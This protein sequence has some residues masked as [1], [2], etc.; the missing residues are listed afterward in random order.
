MCA[1]CV[2]RSAQCED[3]YGQWTVTR[4]P[5]ALRG[6]LLHKPFNVRYASMRVLAYQLLQATRRMSDMTAHTHA[7]TLTAYSCNVQCPGNGNG[8]IKLNASGKYATTI[9]RNQ[10]KS[11]SHNNNNNNDA[12]A[13]K[14]KRINLCTP[15]LRLDIVNISSLKILK[16]PMYVKFVL[17]SVLLKIIFIEYMQQHAT[18]CS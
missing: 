15:L 3:I 12:A 9:T 11:Y 4:P 16:I 17:G 8:K 5:F 10:N 18:C 7:H 1:E 6:R 14:N 2:L 13:N